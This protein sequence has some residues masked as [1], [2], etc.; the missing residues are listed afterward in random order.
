MAEIASG[1]TAVDVPSLVATILGGLGMGWFV[2]WLNPAARQPH[3]S[4][5]YVA[6]ILAMLGLLFFGARGMA[7][8]I[9]GSSLWPR[10]LGFTVLWVVYSIS[11]TLGLE[12]R[13]RMARL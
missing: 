9:D 1:F 11:I 12:A 4:M 7:L 8:Y 6:V 13:R 5:V 10:N 2:L 3:V